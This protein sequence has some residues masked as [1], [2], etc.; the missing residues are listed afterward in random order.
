MKARIQLLVEGILK[1]HRCTVLLAVVERRA[2]L[3]LLGDV[4]MNV[5]LPSCVGVVLGGGADLSLGG[6][7]LVM[8]ILFGTLGLLLG[9][10]WNFEGKLL[11]A[12]FGG[13]WRALSLLCKVKQQHK[14][15][16]VLKSTQKCSENFIYTL[17]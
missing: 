2:P 14:Q 4:L 15:F 11:A 6:L 17:F 10:M 9:Q 16:R 12:R 13:V 8:V 3:W 1:F 5:A 7:G